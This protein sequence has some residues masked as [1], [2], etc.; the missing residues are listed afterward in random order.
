[1]GN[2]WADYTGTDENGD[3]IGDQPV[4]L[5]DN[6]IDYHPLISPVDSYKTPDEKEPKTELIRASVGEPFTVS[7]PSNPSTGYTWTI[8]YDYA[9]LRA[10]EANFEQTPTQSIRVG[11][12]GSSAFVFTPIGPGKTTIRFVYKRPWENIVAETRAYYVEISG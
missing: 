2:Y 5:N 7:L 10:E 12:G 4:I 1:M 8:D 9:L 6:N 3:G 11:A